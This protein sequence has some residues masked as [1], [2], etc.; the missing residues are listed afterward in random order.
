M[1]WYPIPRCMQIGVLQGLTAEKEQINNL[2]DRFSM[3]LAE[4]LINKSLS[5]R[6]LLNN[7]FDS[8]EAIIRRIA[9][10]GYYIPRGPM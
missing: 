4:T 1:A 10:K 9:G 5:L 8:P 6:E 7:P 2:I 3:K